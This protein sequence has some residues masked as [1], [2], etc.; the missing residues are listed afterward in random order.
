L[1]K[2]KDLKIKVKKQNTEY[3]EN[4][5]ELRT[6]LDEFMSAAV[7]RKPADVID[8]GWEFFSKLRRD[9]VIK[10]IP[11]IVL[12]GPIAVGKK[13]ILT[14]LM[15]KFPETFVPPALHTSRH[16]RCALYIPRI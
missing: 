15:D 13:T 9:S 10:A 4:H 8:F 2:L 6:L 1:T 16:P 12:S 3:I 7:D 14:R 11:L 5:P